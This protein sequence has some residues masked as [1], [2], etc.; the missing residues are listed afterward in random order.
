ML[1]R[2]LAAS[3]ERRTC[4]FCALSVLA[5]LFGLGYEGLFISLSED[6]LMNLHFDV[7]EPLARLLLANLFHS[8]RPVEQPG[9]L[10]ARE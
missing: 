1:L 4:V 9:L 6:D 3:A 5:L 7:R 2:N 8:R 10:S